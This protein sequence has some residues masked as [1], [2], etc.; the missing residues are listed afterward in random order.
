MNKPAHNER[1][2]K[3]AAVTPQTILW[4]FQRL[5]PAVTLV[6]AATS[7]SCQNVGCKCRATVSNNNFDLH[8]RQR[9]KTYKAVRVGK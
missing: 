2:C 9:G 1:F 4:K 5:F 8:L 3:M 7:Q 6:E